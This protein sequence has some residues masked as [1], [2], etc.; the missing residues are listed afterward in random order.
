MTLT[1]E[2]YADKILHLYLSFCSHNLTSVDLFHIAK[3]V[4]SMWKTEVIYTKLDF[5]LLSCPLKCMHYWSF[6]KFYNLCIMF[7]FKCSCIR[8]IVI[9]QNP[10]D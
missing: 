3:Q 1:N 10:N 7:S 5:E 8:L 4:T 2:C 6:E 9:A